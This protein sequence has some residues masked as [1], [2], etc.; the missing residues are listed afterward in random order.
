MSMILSTSKPPVGDP[1]MF[2]ATFREVLR[3]HVDLLKA[4]ATINTVPPLQEAHANRYNFYRVL[5]AMQI[6][7][8]L[9]WIIARINEVTNPFEEVKPGKSILIIKDDDLSDIK[10]LYQLRDKS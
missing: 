9:H 8:D 3:E 1:L 10:A 7:P 6:S 4:K 2:D 5:Q